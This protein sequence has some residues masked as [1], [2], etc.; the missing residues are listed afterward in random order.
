MFEEACALRLLGL[1]AA[2]SGELSTAQDR[3]GE[4][5]RILL[6]IGK[7]YE[8]ARLNL[9]AGLSWRRRARRGKSRGI[10]DE[11]V[12]FLRRAVAAY[13]S[14]NLPALAARALFEL[15]RSELLRGLVDEAVLHLDHAASLLPPGE[16]TKRMP[17]R[18]SR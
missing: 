13:E 8:L 4:S 15:S 11:S 9:A 5:S 7:R 10:L 12:A 2:E 3:L 16:A 14:L 18:G 17:G 1:V 6:T